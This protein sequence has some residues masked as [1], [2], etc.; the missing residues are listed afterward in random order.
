MGCKFNFSINTA[1]LLSEISGVTYYQLHFDAPAI[2]RAYESFNPLAERLGIPPA[3]PSMAGFGYAH[4]ST[5]GAEVI[6]PENSEPKPRPII[7]K[8]EDIDNLREPDDYIDTPLVRR[9]LSVLAELQKI[10]PE[11]RNRIGHEM[12]GPVTT[13]VLLMGQEF[14]TLLYDDPGRAHKLL[15]FCTE[16]ALNYH[17]AINRC[18]NNEQSPGP[19][20]IPDDFAGL[21][22]PNFFKEFVVP[23]WERV[24]Q[25]LEITKR[26]LHSELLKVNHLPFLSDLHISSYD[27]GANQFLSPE[28]LSENCPCDFKLRLQEWDIDNYSADELVERYHHLQSYNPSSVSITMKSIVQEPKIYALLEAA[29]KREEEENR[30]ERCAA[31]GNRSAFGGS[32]AGG[33]T[34]RIAT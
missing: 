30:I 22:S 4:V 23:Y 33:L 10:S 12:E 26:S 19:G 7:G 8:P 31:R 21:L 5:L 28:A 18:F 20:G 25:G 11:A 17:A 27:P 3:C 15:D 16:S 9:K 24:Y 13:A 1:A 6:F 34:G 29:R 32:D 14:F 2:V